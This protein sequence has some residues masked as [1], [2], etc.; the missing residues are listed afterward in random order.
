MRVY[1]LIIS[2]LLWFFL[3]FSPT[4]IFYFE[5]ITQIC[6]IVRDF[7]LIICLFQKYILVLLAIHDIQL[8]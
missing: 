8:N 3:S 1:N 7:I 4:K 2:W 6:M 5:T